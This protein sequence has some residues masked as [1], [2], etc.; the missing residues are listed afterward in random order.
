MSR[1]LNS[2]YRSRFFNLINRQSR[3][4]IVKGD[5]AIRHLKVAAIWGVQ[6][7]L[8]PVYLFVQATLYAGHQIL[9]EAES[10]W[11]RLKAF[12]QSQSQP[13]KPPPTSDTPIQR[14][15]KEVKILPLPNL[16]GSVRSQP[17]FV[18]V[19]SGE[20]SLDKTEVNQKNLHH[21][22]SINEQNT[23]FCPHSSNLD[24]SKQDNSQRWI[25]QGVASLLVERTLVLVTIENEI[26]D[27]LTPQQQQKISARITWEIANLLRQ[28]RLVQTS[29]FNKFKRR[30]SRLDHPTLVLPLRLFWR[31]MAWIQTSPVAIAIN[32]FGESTLVRSS[33][34]KPNLFQ[35]LETQKNLS[36]QLIPLET[37]AFVERTI[38]QIESHSLVQKSPVAIAFLERSHKF[39]QTLKR[40]FITPHN[41]TSLTQESEPPKFWLYALIY[42]A[43]DYFFGKPSS[44]LP[45]KNYQNQE[46]I[47]QKLINTPSQLPKNKSTLTPRIALPHAEELADSHEPDPWLTWDDLFGNSET[48]TQKQNYTLL[49]QESLQSVT[50]L[51]EG[52]NSQ[53]P[54]IPEQSVWG[55]L[56]RHLNATQ[57]P[58]KLT[59]PITQTQ[60][61]QPPQP[62]I[63]DSNLKA[64]P[65][66]VSDRTQTTR[67][68]NPNK[69][70][71]LSK[72]QKTHSAKTNLP[73]SRQE[74][75]L[76]PQLHPT[77]QKSSFNLEQQPDWIETQAT[78]T[79]YV[80]HPL[81][82]L[83]EWLDIGMLWIEELVIKIW[84]WLRKFW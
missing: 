7:L 50:L 83:L 41:S 68:T 17:S 47:L 72:T 48:Q 23:L 55:T 81:E 15:L 34:E 16:S 26:L 82:Q 64:V 19:V 36:L 76:V 40:P 62:I 33:V 1:P 61:L 10:G 4:W 22:L 60:N 18:V 51:P 53:T 5:R 35:P 63:Q 75:P 31:L 45:E 9:S 28:Q 8:Y 29:K 78:P 6:I 13:Q 74:T 43:I 56:K 67:L 38:T 3:R 73:P 30:L 71:K 65:L 24:T 2:R 46:L 57:S 11:A 52:V 32:L 66:S 49:Q 20:W 84:R 79:G 21:Q 69:T 39:I 14:V 59:S 70:Q 25:I 27:I 42:A 37:L 54:V 44:S 80:K 12:T 58:G 77:P